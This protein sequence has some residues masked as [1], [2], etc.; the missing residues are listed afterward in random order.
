MKSIKIKIL[1]GMIGVSLMLALVIGTVSSV[2]NY[3][4]TQTTLEH[5]LMETARVAA[6][7]ITTEMKAYENVAVDTGMLTRASPIPTSPQGKSRPYWMS[8]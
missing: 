4:S 5:T 2:V 1:C 7:Q 3:S 8:M 6:N